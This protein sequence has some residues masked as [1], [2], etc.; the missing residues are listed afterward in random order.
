MEPESTAAAESTTGHGWSLAGAVIYETGSSR[1]R[2]ISPGSPN[3][4]FRR[5]QPARPPGEVVWSDVNGPE[6]APVQARARDCQKR[7]ITRGGTARTPGSRSSFRTN[8]SSFRHHG[9]HPAIGRTHGNCIDQL[10][11]M[12][13][14]HQERSGGAI[15]RKCSV[16]VAAAPADPSPL[17]I[18]GNSRDQHQVCRV[19]RGGGE[20]RP[21]LEDPKAPG[22]QLF[23]VVE[24]GKVELVV[25]LAARKNTPLFRTP[26]RFEQR[27]CG[28]LA[29]GRSVQRDDHRAQEL[30][31]SGDVFRDPLRSPRCL[32]GAD[33][34][35]RRQ[36]ALP[37][38]CLLRSEPHANSP[39]STATKD[40]L[41]VP[42]MAG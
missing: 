28:D 21:G 25:S 33:R 16:V 1:S 2:A 13:K 17:P 18:E 32:F 27:S 37:Q 8:N 12:R 20:L 15:D 22:L 9:I 6:F 29:C 41:A 4:S 26:G 36:H 14:S 11:R 24:L 19:Q 30:G 42:T 40:P 3:I 23:P 39:S 31:T 7:C 38:L 35:A 34:L 5:T 10:N